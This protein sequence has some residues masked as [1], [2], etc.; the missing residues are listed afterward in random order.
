M[1]NNKK[2]V[3]LST[4]PRRIELL[5]KIVSN[6]EIKSPNFNENNSSKLLPKKLVL[7]NAVGKVNSLKHQ[8][9]KIY[10]SC[11]T[12]VAFKN[13]ILGKPKNKID[14]FNMLKKL[15]GNVHEVYTGIAMRCDDVIQTKIVITKVVFNTLKD[16][17]IEKYIEQF[18]PIDKAG[19][20]GI[21]DNFRLVKKIEGDYEN[22][23][24]FPTKFIEDLLR[25]FAYKF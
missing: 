24:G 21:Q 11:D 3:L 20:Y 15:S 4:S 18:N 10:I 22:V 16:K 2:I 19:G 8:K 9:N 14:C 6:F 13:E 25:K 12:V 5:K 7:E 17:D 23:M 1:L